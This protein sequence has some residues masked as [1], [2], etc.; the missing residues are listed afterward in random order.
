MPLVELVKLLEAEF[1]ISRNSIY[2]PISQA[3]EIETIAFPDKPGKLCRL[4]MD[5][6]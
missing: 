1:K 6:E 2:A 5:A 4:K 3:T